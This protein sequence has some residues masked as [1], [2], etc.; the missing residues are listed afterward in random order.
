MDVTDEQS[1]VDVV[2]QIIREQGRIDVLFNIAGYGSYGAVEDI[3]LE[4]AKR[5]FEVNLFGLA[6]LTQL[7]LPHMRKQQSG[8]NINFMEN[9][10]GFSSP[11][12]IANVV[13]IAIQSKKTKTRYVAGNLAKHFLF[14]R[15]IL[16]ERMFDRILN[17]MLGQ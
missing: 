1:M 4:E 15:R 13:L 5:Q 9:M 14:M 6:R 2:T 10:K 8:T 17:N 7:V 11:N 12:V 3:P 16:S